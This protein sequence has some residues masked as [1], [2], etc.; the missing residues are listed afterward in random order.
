MG[1]TSLAIKFE[2]G[3]NNNIP[4]EAIVKAKIYNNGKVE[5]THTSHRSNNLSK[6]KKKNANEY[7][8]IE[9][10]EIKEYEKPPNFKSDKSLKR[11]LNNTVRPLLE[12]NFSGGNNEKFITLTFD[13]APRFDELSKIFTNFWNRLCRYY[14]K[15][16]LIL[17]CVWI[18]EIQ[19]KREVWHIHTLIKEI[20]N[21]NLFIEWKTLH[22]IWGLGNVWVNSIISMYD[23]TS[24]QINIEKEMNTLPLANAHSL[25][26]IIDYM[27]KLK[28]KK[29]IIPSKGH[30]YGIKGNLK[31]PDENVDNFKNICER[32]LTQ[33]LLVNE[34]T[35]LVRDKDTD[36]IYNRIHKQTWLGPK[37]NNEDK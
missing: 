10:G 18:K 23:Y 19:I 13:I 4:D 11:T 27:C 15:Q 37:P 17:A 20:N 29:G 8:D 2:E 33:H 22:K 24:Y 12:N 26:K 21:K 31:Q 1:G 25:N 7:I 3:E 32:Y 6:Y 28:S 30:V 35:L 16:S 36:N 34:N 5:V 9:T 14:S